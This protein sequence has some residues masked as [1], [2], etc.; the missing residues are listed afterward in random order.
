MYV[1]SG[2]RTYRQ[3]NNEIMPDKDKFIFQINWASTVHLHIAFIALMF[4]NR[5]Y[6]PLYAGWS[7]ELR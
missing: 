5:Y 7:P 4:R 6:L 2:L 1:R 3:M